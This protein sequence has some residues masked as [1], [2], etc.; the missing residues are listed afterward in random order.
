MHILVIEDEVK[1]ANSYKTPVLVGRLG[2]VALIYR[3][4]LTVSDTETALKS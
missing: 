4:I 3:G 2:L 1:V